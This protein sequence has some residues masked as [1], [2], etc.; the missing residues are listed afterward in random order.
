M[1][2]STTSF[3]LGAVLSFT[4]STAS[5][6]TTDPRIKRQRLRLPAFPKRQLAS[7]AL[8]NAAYS[9]GGGVDGKGADTDFVFMREVLVGATN[10]W[11]RNPG[12][13]HDDGANV[14][15]DRGGW[16]K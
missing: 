10:A 9:S 2:A 14:I 7:T 8:T 16:M 5:S 4:S 11:L 13:A 3:V 12:F 1:S 6:S 15:E